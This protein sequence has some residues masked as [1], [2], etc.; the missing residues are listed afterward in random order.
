MHQSTPV[1]L[2]NEQGDQVSFICTLEKKR[3]IQFIHLL[4]ASVQRYTT[5]TRS[6]QEVTAPG[7]CSTELH[8]KLQIAALASVFECWI[9]SQICVYQPALEASAILFALDTAGL[10]A[11]PCFQSLC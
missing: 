6:L 4:S 9:Y 1:K 2:S 8:L 10:A 11:F 5:Y 3:F 7:R